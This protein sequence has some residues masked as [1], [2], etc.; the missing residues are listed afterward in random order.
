MTTKTLGYYPC[1]CCH[2]PLAIFTE[3]GQ[4]R[5]KEAVGNLMKKQ[6]VGEVMEEIGKEDE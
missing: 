4:P 6:K 3:D 5:L 2:H 1:P